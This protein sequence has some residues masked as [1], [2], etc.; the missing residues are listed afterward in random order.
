MTNDDRREPTPRDERDSVAEDLADALFSLQGSYP[1]ALTR[2]CRTIVDRTTLDFARAMTRDFLDE[3]DETEEGRGIGAGVATG[4]KV[5]AIV[6]DETSPIPRHTRIGRANDAH[7]L[8]AETGNPPKILTHEVG[9]I[10]AAVP[11]DHGIV[12]GAN[13]AARGR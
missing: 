8:Y 3:K 12:H 9:P 6:A 2:L 4:P 13:G 10:G 1:S 5:A 11:A 7:E